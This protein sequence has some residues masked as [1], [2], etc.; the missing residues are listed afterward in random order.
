MSDFPI[1]C[2]TCLGPNPYVRMQK[3][4][5]GGVC[6]I[7]GRPYT[8]FR[9]KAGS[10]SRYKKTVI[11]QIIAKAKNVCQVCMMDLD[12]GLPV[13]IRDKALNIQEEILPMTRV[14]KEYAL[15]H[16]EIDEAK[17]NK[18]ITNDLIIKL[19]RTEPYYKRNQARLCSFF[20]KDC[21]NRGTECPYRHEMPTTTSL[22]K[23]NYHT[24]YYGSDDPVAN[25]MLERASKLP[26]LVP[27]IDLNI[28]TLFIGNVTPAI[29]KEDLWNVFYM[30]GE[31]TSFKIYYLRSCAL[32]T[33]CK[34]QDA[35]NACVGLSRHLVVKGHTLVLRWGNPHRQN[36]VKQKE[37]NIDMTASNIPGQKM[38]PYAAMDSAQFGSL[39]NEKHFK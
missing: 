16:M 6:H 11:C 30:Y 27:P 8:S 33:Y 12:Y 32:V 35:E 25:K 19:G 13:Q 5:E 39:I 17:F 22:S 14:N 20:A 38:K 31:I 26:S 21:C 29:T 2:E 28:T 37:E 23:Q 4:F 24:R 9:W 36:T 15:N 10:D 34:R 18:N 7:S 3:F 1:V